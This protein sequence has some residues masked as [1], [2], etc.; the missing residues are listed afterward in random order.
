MPHFDIV[1]LVKKYHYKPVLDGLSFTLA[2]GDFCV[3]V[4]DNGSG[5]TTLLRILAT[6]IQA[7]AGDIA[8]DGEPLGENPA[9]RQRIGYV[10]HQ[11]MFYHDLSAAENLMHYA[12]L[13]R[14]P[15]H[16]ERVQ[17]SLRLAGLENQQEQPVR[18]FSRGM[19]Q[20]LSI[21]RA[22][23]HDP[24]ILLF[25]EPYTG[26]DKEAAQTLDRRLAAL[27]Q[28]GRVIFLAAHQ[29]RRLISLASHIAW[30]KD[31]KINHHLPTTGLAAAPDLLAYLQEAQ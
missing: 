22:I 27:H 3:L 19:L 14:C 5:K 6:L 21:A 24:D 4:G 23:L 31:G 20:R 15:Q 12:H 28:P 7:D 2:D 17:E 9:Q 18:T 11:V 1:G 26:L 10:G 16:S 30:L 13:Y 8:L 25:D 29:P